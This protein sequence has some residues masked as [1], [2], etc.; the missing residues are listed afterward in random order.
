MSSSG[1]DPAHRKP[2]HLT[3]SP[4]FDH[5]IA[6]APDGQKII[7][8]SDRNGHEDLYLL[9][10]DDKEH[11]KLV[12]ANQFKVRQLTDTPDAEIGVSFAPD[13]KRVAFIRAGMA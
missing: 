1:S 8:A 3:N 11:P 7:F 5:G 4:A 9:E 10:A 12:E 2:T 6:W 13:G